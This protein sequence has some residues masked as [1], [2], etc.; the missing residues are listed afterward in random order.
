MIKTVAS[1]IMK[2]HDPKAIMI[3]LFAFDNDESFCFRATGLTAPKA[4]AK[5]KRSNVEDDETDRKTVSVPIF[6]FG[7]P[8]SSPIL[9]TRGRR[10]FDVYDQKYDSQQ[11]AND[12][13]DEI[14][15]GQKIVFPAHPRRVGDD[16][17]L[18]PFERNDGIIVPDLQLVIPGG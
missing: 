4:A 7:V 12:R 6:Y 10:H 9:V 17:S 16:E 3:F 11:N 14:C 15:D 18:S 5:A 13:D 2:Y 8:C 1:H